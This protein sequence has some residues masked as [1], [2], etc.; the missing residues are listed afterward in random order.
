M[1][2]SRQ[3]STISIDIDLPLNNEHFL[4]MM[5]ADRIVPTLDDDFWRKSTVSIDIDSPTNSVDEL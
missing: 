2:I 5:S 4:E 1:A 3:K